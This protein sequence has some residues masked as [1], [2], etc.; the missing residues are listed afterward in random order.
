MSQVSRQRSASAGWF[1]RFAARTARI[2]GS[3]FAFLLALAS[4][5]IW[6]VLGPS[7]QWSNTWQLI[8]NSITN[9]VTY[10]VVFVIQ[11]SQTRDSDAINLKLNELIA[12]NRSASN[13]LINVEDLSDEE[14][15][16]LFKRYED[17]RTE[18]DRRRQ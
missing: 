11:S 2:V 4:I 15:N 17:I 14:L 5:I 12:T 7:F 9:I 16:T 10:L 1:S 6:L 13:E 18:W 3:P 8:I